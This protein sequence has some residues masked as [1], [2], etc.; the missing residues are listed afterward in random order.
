MAKKKAKRVRRE[1]TLEEKRRWKQARKETEGEKKENIEARVSEV[2]DILRIH[3][4]LKMKPGK[5]SGGD[6]QR[7]ALARALVRRPAAFLMDEPLGA[8]DT[9]LR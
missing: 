6:K 5:L 3:H 9:E 7:V 4:L 8:L 2:V 1:L